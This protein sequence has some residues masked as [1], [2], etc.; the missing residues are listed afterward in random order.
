MGKRGIPRWRV[1]SY[2]ER[3]SVKE[4]PQMKEMWSLGESLPSA[5][6]MPSGKP[7]A[8]SS[9]KGLGHLAFGDEL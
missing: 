1:L 4:G 8:L 3:S 9:S 2:G 5:L 6:L 7:P